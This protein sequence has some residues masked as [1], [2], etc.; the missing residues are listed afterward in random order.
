MNLFARILSHGFALLVVALLAIGLIYRGELFP[1]MELPAFLALDETRK[2][3]A[4]SA[5]ASTGRDGPDQ[6]ASAGAEQAAGERVPAPAISPQPIETPQPVAAA[7]GDAAETVP[8]AADDTGVLPGLVARDTD[9]AA[10][11]AGDAVSTVVDTATTTADR[12]AAAGDAVPADAMADEAGDAASRPVDTATITAEK[13]AEAGVAV[14][15]ADAA[16]EAGD[17]SLL[18][19]AGFE[20]AR[21]GV[22]T[23]S[24]VLRATKI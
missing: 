22:T 2:D 5:A 18:R 21:A 3:E 10:D 15:A 4:D 14:P 1:D 9:D 12:D 6:A 7:A 17:L 20:K 19:D 13:D 11:T 16:A 8:A 23:V 24:E